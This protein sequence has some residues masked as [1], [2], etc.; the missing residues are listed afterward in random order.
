MKSFTL[1]NRKL[2][3]GA[4]PALLPEEVFLNASEAIVEYKGSGM[5]ILEI[6]H[7]GALFHDILD[8][9]KA[10]VRELC[11]LN[12]GYFSDIRIKQE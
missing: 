3:F 4:G 7:R 2:N 11:E 6:P 12:D 10:L 9:N 8:E 1:D 5:S